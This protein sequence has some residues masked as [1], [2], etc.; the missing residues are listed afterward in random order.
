MKC[1]AGGRHSTGT[2]CKTCLIG[3]AWF[4]PDCGLASPPGTPRGRDKPEDPEYFDLTDLSGDLSVYETIRPPM[5]ADN[6]LPVPALPARLRP[7][8]PPVISAKFCA[9]RKCTD[10]Q[11]AAW[12]DDK[13]WKG[14]RGRPRAVAKGRA[15]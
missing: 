7:V 1:L 11:Q 2:A 9:K 12:Y 13:F 5:A 15:S 6:R 14:G 4:D 8:I 3:L 10:V